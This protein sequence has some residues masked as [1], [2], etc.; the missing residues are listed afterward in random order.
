MSPS[1][2]EKDRTFRTTPSKRKYKDDDCSD[3]DGVECSSGEDSDDSSELDS[4]SKDVYRFPFELQGNFNDF[5][6]FFKQHKTFWIYHIFNFYKLQKKPSEKKFQWGR[7][8]ITEPFK[9][10]F[11]HF[12]SKGE[13]WKE[14]IKFFQAKFKDTKETVMYRS[15]R[16]DDVFDDLETKYNEE[17]C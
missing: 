16:F 13:T 1:L 12:V 10:G 14:I 15:L 7:A 3:D 4:P 8:S 9:T 5:K 2:L 6:G 17:Y 11:S